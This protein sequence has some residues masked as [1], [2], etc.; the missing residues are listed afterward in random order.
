[1]TE[2]DA[3]VYD[4]D[5][6]LVDLDVDWD[7][8]AADVLERYES[9]GVEPPS[10]D[11]WKLLDG[12]GDPEL[13]AD[14]ESTVAAHEREGALTAPRLARAEELLERTVPVGVC[15]LNCEAACRTALAEHG[16][17]DAVD[18]VVGRDTVAT[19]KPDPEPL[20]EAVR[21]LG[22]P[23]DGAVFVGD[24]ARDELTAQRAGTAFEYV[25][26]GPSG[27]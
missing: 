1:M 25:D 20:L 3:V 9:A 23:P 27:V 22:C 21:K 2:Y 10:T 8:V 11:L 19:R 18:V 7:A 13:A 26:D 4:L 16:L 15:S 12:A 6:T 17:A 14:V 5:G 24:S